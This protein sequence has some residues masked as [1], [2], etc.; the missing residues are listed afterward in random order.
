MSNLKL[1]M[2]EW[3]WRMIFLE[4]CPQ[5]EVEELKS[6]IRDEWN[7]KKEYWTQRIQEEAAF[8]RELKQKGK[9]LTQ[10]IKDSLEKSK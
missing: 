7:E 3:E 10:R 9:D 6:A 1:D 8:S 4:D 5:S 2:A